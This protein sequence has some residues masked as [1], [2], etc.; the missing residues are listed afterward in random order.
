VPEKKVQAPNSLLL[1]GD[2]SGNAPQSFERL[3]T[4]TSSCVV[5]RTL[6]ELD[7]PTRVRLMDDRW[8]DE[9]LPPT[10]AWDGSIKLS[11]GLM[12]VGN[13]L[14]AIYLERKM[15]PQSVRLQIYVNHPTEPD[16]IAIVVRTDI[17][18]H[19]SSTLVP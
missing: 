14:G 10:L 3:V 19:P 18:Y 11:D 16:H 15:E 13:I 8:Y 2:L 12:K 5:I 7:G 6:K 1:I 4:A 17:F 9:P